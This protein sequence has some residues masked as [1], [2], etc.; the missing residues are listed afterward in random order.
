MAAPN[1]KPETQRGS[2]DWARELAAR[3]R[4]LETVILARL[5]DRQAVDD[6]LQEVAL[7]TVQQT[8]SLR[9]PDRVSAW[10][11]RVARS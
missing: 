9:D 2:I 6:V 1:P 10:L 4:W 7:A 11:Y 3:R 5:N 8:T